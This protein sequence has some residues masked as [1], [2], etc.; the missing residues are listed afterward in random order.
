ME[1][2]N[3]LATSNNQQSTEGWSQPKEVAAGTSA[4]VSY[5]KKKMR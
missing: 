1:H 3:F 2:D 5:G 4:I